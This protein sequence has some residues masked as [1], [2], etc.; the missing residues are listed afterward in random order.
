MLPGGYLKSAAKTDGHKR[1]RQGHIVKEKGRT[2]CLE[3]Y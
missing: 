3:K 1:E 2:V